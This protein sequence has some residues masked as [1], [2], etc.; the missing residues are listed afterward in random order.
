MGNKIIEQSEHSHD[1]ST[2]DGYT[3]IKEYNT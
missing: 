1:N 2:D 3:P